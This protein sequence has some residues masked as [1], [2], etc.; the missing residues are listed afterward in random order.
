[1]ERAQL[2]KNC[3]LWERPTWEKFREL[4]AVPETPLGQRMSVRRKEQR[5]Q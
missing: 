1:M 3:S 4:F 2:V 5:G